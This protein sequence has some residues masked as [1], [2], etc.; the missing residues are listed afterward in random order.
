MH[1]K[2]M[3]LVTAV[4]AGLLQTAEAK[5]ELATPFK[6]KM[7]LQ[8]RM[9]VPVWGRADAGEKVKVAFA[10]AT[11]ETTAGAD[12]RWMVRLPKMEACSEGR[13]LT[14]NDQTVND[15]LVGEVWFCAGQSNTELPLV[16][17]APMAY[18][19]HFTDR[20][21]KMTAQ[22]THETKVRFAYCSDYRWAVT[23][24]ERYEG[25]FKEWKEFIPENLGTGHSFSAMGVYFAL[26][27]HNTL[28]IPVGIVGT[29]WGG[30]NI[31]AWTPRSGYENMPALK[32]TA[33]FKVVPET[34]WKPEMAKGVISG[35]FQQPTVLWNEMVAPWTPFAARGLIWYQGCNNAAEGALYCDKMHALYNG[36]AKEF[37]N[38]GF[39]LYFVQLAPWVQSWWDIELAQ[40]KFADEEPNAGMVVT[41]DVGNNADIHPNE[42]GTVGR[43]LAALALKRDYGFEKIVADY[44]RVVSAKALG[45]EVVVKCSNVNRWELYNADWGC[46]VGFELKAPD[47]TWHRAYLLN[48]NNGARGGNPWYTRGEVEGRDL[49]VVSDEVDE[50]AGIRYLFQSPWTSFLYSCDSGLPLAAFIREW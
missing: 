26:Q 6:D 12:G 15:V 17:G 35:P 3:L 7:V 31:D 2:R 43:R 46:Q 22:L 39:R 24:K 47:G 19:P 40:E 23:P 21:G 16:A 18:N 11:R 41:P 32:A 45:R 27:L 34:E 14:V 10:G 33:D 20:E 37:G 4:V 28:D 38:P 42:K 48:C 13:A 8:R 5:V 30:T 9:E 1:V 50:P 25:E 44:P 29:Y 49:H 36:W